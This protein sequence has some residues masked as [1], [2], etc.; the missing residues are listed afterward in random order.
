MVLMSCFGKHARTIATQ[1]GANIQASNSWDP[2]WTNEDP[3]DAKDNDLMHTR[4]PLSRAAGC[5]LGNFHTISPSV[6]SWGSTTVKLIPWDFSRQLYLPTTPTSYL[7]L[8]VARTLDS[9]AGALHMSI[10]AD[11]SLLQDEVEVHK[12]MLF[13]KWQVDSIMDCL[14]P[15]VNKWWWM[16][17]QNASG[18]IQGMCGKT[19]KVID[20]KDREQSCHGSQFFPQ[21][22]ERFCFVFDPRIITY[23]SNNGKERIRGNWTHITKIYCNWMIEVK[24]AIK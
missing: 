7:D 13:M 9:A 3:K 22:D 16:M 15:L 17:F 14:D 18:E 21:L 6:P 24:E 2:M 5:T 10:P 19:S 23:L 20:F 1:M 4:G 12:N 11:A 8:N